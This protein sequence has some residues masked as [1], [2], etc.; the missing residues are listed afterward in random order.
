MGRKIDI[1]C[2]DGSPLGV[3]ERT[4]NG[5]DGQ[6][7]VG[8]AELALL[9][10]CRAWEMYYNDVTLY[11]NPRGGWA[12]SF[13]QK[14]LREFDPQEDRDILIVFRSPNQNAYEAKGKKLWWSCDQY[15]IGEFRDFATHVDKIVCISPFHAKYFKDI[16]GIENTNVIDLPVR[17]WEYN[18]KIPKVPHRC[19]FTSIPERGLTQLSQAWPKI[20]AEVPDASLTITSDW[21]LWSQDASPELVMPY[22]LAFARMPNINYRAAVKRSELIQIQMEAQLHVYPC[23]YEELFCIAVAE[24]QVAGTLPI[25]SDVGALATTNMARVIHGVP[26]DS[27]WIDLFVKNTVELL[28]DPKLAEKQEHI[29]EVAM[30]RFSIETI[31][32]Q[33]EA[34]FG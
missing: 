16:Y 4:I 19:I 2:N 24:S 34:V 1:I 6:M 3:S 26:T 32:P 28:N 31:L 21:R 25:T 30:K 29:R 17:T 20:L 13:K 27:E 22:R 7:G 23:L 10:M 33:W 12:S 14:T 11:N 18:D 15:T 8:G 9:T 5:D